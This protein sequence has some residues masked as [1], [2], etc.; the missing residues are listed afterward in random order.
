MNRKKKVFIVATHIDGL[1]EEEL[2]SVLKSVQG[3]LNSVID[4]QESIQI[5]PISSLEALKAKQQQNNELLRQSNIQELEEALMTYMESQAYLVAE[6][7]SIRFD[8]ERLEES[9]VESE[10]EEREESNERERLRQLRIQRLQL[11]TK[12]EY[13]LLKEYGFDLLAFR[14]DRLTKLL[15]QWKEKVDRNN[16]RYKKEIAIFFREFRKTVI[17]KVS[18]TNF[19]IDDIK[20]DYVRHNEKMHDRY[21]KM[22]HEFESLITQIHQNVESVIVEEDVLFVGT[23]EAKQENI[24]LNWPAFKQKIKDIVLSQDV[25]DYDKNIF[26]HYE[27]DKKELTHSYNKKQKKLE[28]IKSEKDRVE[29]EKDMSLQ[30][31]EENHDRRIKNIGSMP[32]PIPETKTKGILWWKEEVVIGYDYSSQERWKESIQSS[33]KEY[34]QMLDN[35]LID[36]EKIMSELKNTEGELHSVIDRLDSELEELNSSLFNELFASIEDWKKS[37]QSLYKNVED[38]IEALWKIQEKSAV[39]QFNQHTDNVREQ[40]IQFIE[41]SL[42]TEL[43]LIK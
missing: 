8:L 39:Q 34:G 10:E 12:R 9:I 3:K 35:R 31:L 15:R 23:L 38:E 18:L 21:E 19:S 27:K 5:Y 13:D 36:F 37:A 20:E 43:Q 29:H 16:S 30:S 25:M 17:R 4:S 24:K 33:H 32:S 41:R 22:I 14:E 40:F 7:E 26:S 2:V 6:V 28:R 11:L 42:Q 1:T